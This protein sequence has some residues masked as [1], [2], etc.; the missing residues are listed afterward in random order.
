M[1][2]IAIAALFIV[3]G[4]YVRRHYGGAALAALTVA[5]AAATSAIASGMFLALLRG[6]GASASTVANVLV[7]GLMIVSQ[8][9]SYGCAAVAIHVMH[10]NEG[11]WITAPGFLFAL[12]GYVAGAVLAAL[13]AVA[14]VF[15]GALGMAK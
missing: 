6:L 12:L 5:T 4:L 8:S 14:A 13:I 9:L 2:A 15:A 10:R 1:S 3:G 11:P 7:I